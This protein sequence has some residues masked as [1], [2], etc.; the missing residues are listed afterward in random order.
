MKPYFVA[1]FTRLTDHVRILG[2]GLELAC[3]GGLCD[4]YHYYVITTNFFVLGETP[5]HILIHV[6]ESRWCG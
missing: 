3:N 6:R 4:E 5:I 1:T 2:S